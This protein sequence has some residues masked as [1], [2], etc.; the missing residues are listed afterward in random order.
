MTKWELFIQYINSNSIIR[1]KHLSD[2]YLNLTRNAG[3]IKRIKPGVY[4]RVIKIPNISTTKIRVLAYNKEER[5]KFLKIISRKEKLK[6][7][8]NI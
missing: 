7:L 3:F 4:M 5:D 6:N 1:R 2:N 8:K